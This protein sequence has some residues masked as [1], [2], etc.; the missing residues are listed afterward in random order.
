M[1]GERLG[2]TVHDPGVVGAVDADRVRRLR[3]PARKLLDRRQRHRLERQLAT[4][5]LQLLAELLLGELVRRRQY[6]H[7]REA[8]A[9][10]RHL[11]VLEVHA[12]VEQHARHGRHDPRAV[13]SRG[14]EHERTHGATLPGRPAH[15]GDAH[16]RARSANTCG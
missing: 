8:A 10:V 5:G 15:R 4:D 11:G 7:D 12:V 14:R 3:R 16:R 13:A 1:T 6:E 2:D 9:Q